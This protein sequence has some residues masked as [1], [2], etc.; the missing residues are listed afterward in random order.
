[1][2]EQFPILASAVILLFV[3]GVA[4]LIWVWHLSRELRG[5]ALEPDDDETIVGIVAKIVGVVLLIGSISAFITLALV[6]YG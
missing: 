4:L 2:F 5:D 6:A 3:I 1:M